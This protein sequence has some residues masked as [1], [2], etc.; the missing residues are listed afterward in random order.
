MIM[1]LDETL[2][3]GEM[4]IYKDLHNGWVEEEQT[5]NVRQYGK[6]Y[7]T[8]K[9]MQQQIDNLNNVIRE[10]NEWLGEE[11]IAGCYEELYRIGLKDCHNKLTELK[12]KYNVSNR[13]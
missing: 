3:D 7:Q 9:N 13:D 1:I 8:M 6:T 5:I 12:E 4:R 11:Y 2:K 10:L